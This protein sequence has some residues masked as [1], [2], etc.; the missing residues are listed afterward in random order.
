MVFKLSSIS[1]LGFLLLA[2]TRPAWGK[3]GM[4]GGTVQCGQANQSGRRIGGGQETEK[5]EYPWKIGLYKGHGSRYWC[6]GTIISKREILTAAHCVIYSVSGYAIPAEELRVKVGDHNRMEED[7]EIVFEVSSYKAH[8]SYDRRYGY[9]SLDYDFAILTL[10]RDIE[11]S[12]E[13]SP[14]CL[15][16]SKG[17]DEHSQT[18][19]SGW[20]YT[21]SGGSFSNVL[22][23][24]TITT[25]TNDV[26]KQKIRDYLGYTSL[27]ITDRMLCGE[28]P[29]V[30]SCHGDSGGPW[31]TR[32]CNNNY[33]L[34]GITSWGPRKGYNACPRGGL[35]VAARVS[36]QLGWIKKNM[37][38]PI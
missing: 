7:G 28:A 29:G 17:L 4:N 30:I 16:V 35:D 36:D 21:T 32:D 14:V 13:V 15:P 25:M 26:C 20:G 18:V 9:N 3:P 27:R 12:K 11:F 1:G 31:V 6:G 10:S 2:L 37:W 19:V 22:L 24:M 33:V 38:F 8:E 5:N 23:D 34:I